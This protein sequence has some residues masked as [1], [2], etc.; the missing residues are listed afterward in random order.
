MGEVCLRGA[1]K[2]QM[3]YLGMFYYSTSFLFPYFSPIITGNTESFFF[4]NWG[5]NCMCITWGPSRPFM[6]SAVGILF[7]LCYHNSPVACSLL[8]A[9]QFESTYSVSDHKP[10][11]DWGHPSKLRDVTCKQMIECCAIE[12]STGCQI[13][14]FI[15]T[16]DMSFHW[17]A[18]VVWARMGRYTCHACSKD[19]DS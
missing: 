7:L 6:G 15:V 1:K 11:P 12:S 8:C 16:A 17:M 3:S 13:R 4:H 14:W 10:A 18:S 2:H 9:S 19:G 5:K